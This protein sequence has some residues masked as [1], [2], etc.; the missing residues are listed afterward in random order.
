LSQGCLEIAVVVG[1]SRGDHK[2]I[3]TGMIRSMRL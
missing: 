2:W 1:E 3:A